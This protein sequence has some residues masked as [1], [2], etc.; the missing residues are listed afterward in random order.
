MS[1]NSSATNAIDARSD[2][3]SFCVA[4][5]EAL[6][7]ERPFRAS[8]QELSAA[9]CRGTVSEAP[10]EK[11]FPGGLGGAAAGPA[12]RSEGRWP[13]MRALVAELDRAIAN[14]RR[15]AA[16][17]A[18]AGDLEAQAGAGVGGA[19]RPRGHA[20][21]FWPAARATAKAWRAR[22]DRYARRWTELYGGLR[23]QHPRAGGAWPRCST[24]GLSAQGLEDL[25]ALV[26]M[27]RQPSGGDRKCGQRGERARQPRTPGD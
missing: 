6:Y 5:Y 12:P 11:Q 10:T 7:D 22:S 26:K 21:L 20:P 24:C 18:E 19:R 1:P 13:P 3:F 17:A 2:Q 8:L 4:L 27:F 15:L 25:R 14:R 23:S 9:V 16:A